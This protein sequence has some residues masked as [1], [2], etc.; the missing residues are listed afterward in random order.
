M[1]Q[2]ARFRPFLSKIDQAASEDSIFN[3]DLTP[4]KEALSTQ[5][6][7]M[8]ALAMPDDSVGETVTMN[9]PEG[10]GAVTFKRL[11]VEYG[12][13]QPGSF[14]SI[15]HS[16]LGR[17]FPKGCD[18]NAEIGKLDTDVARYEKVSGEPISDKIM[19]GVVVRAIAHE[20]ELQKH[21]FRSLQRLRTY[22]E[23]KREIVSALA[24]ER[25]MTGDDP[26]D[27]GAFRTGK[28]K[29]KGKDGKGQKMCD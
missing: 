26:M 20:A 29:G 1:A 24:A 18:I 22:A 15:M 13:S 9:A 11:L 23:V 6:Y 19:I 8:L 5:L 4:Q 16:I 27:V 12:P 14:L 10:E 7:F 25:T 21:I 2:D 28:G 3:V 17:E